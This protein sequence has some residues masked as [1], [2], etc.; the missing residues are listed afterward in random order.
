MYCDGYSHEETEIG[1]HCR[2]TPWRILGDLKDVPDQCSNSSCQIQ[3]QPPNESW[4]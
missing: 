4:T 3:G 2:P 1:K